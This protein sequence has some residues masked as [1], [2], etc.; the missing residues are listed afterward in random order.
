[1]ADVRETPLPDGSL[2]AELLARARALVP[3]LAERA[4]AATAARNVPDETIAEYR[5]AG[6]LRALQPRRFGGY[7]QS[8]GV[9]LRIVE[10]LTEGCASSA[11]VYAVLGE[12]QWVIALLPERGQEDIWAMTR[13]RWRREASCR[14]P[15]LAGV[16]KGGA[17][18]AATRSPAGACMHNGRSSA[19][20][21]KM[22]PATNIRAIWRCQWARS[23]SSTTGIRLGCAA[24]A[25]EALCCATCSSRASECFA[26]RPVGRHSAGAAG[27]YGLPAAARAPLLPGAVRF[28][29]GGFRAGAQGTGPAAVVVARARNGAVRPDAH[30]TRRGRGAYRNGQPDFRDSPGRERRVSGCRAS[31][32][33]SQRFTQ[34]PRRDA[35]FWVVEKGGRRVG[36]DQ[37]R[38]NGLRQRPAQF[39]DARHHGDRDAHHSERTGRD[40]AVQAVG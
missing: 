4:T 15:R 26:A 18:A 31:D 29:G 32:R 7:Q 19:P 34:S 11:W 2:G 13:R 22:R 35:G 21:A 36:G 3:N 10:A 14:A 5:R 17:S 27:A 8:V 6:I 25:A 39:G 28:A 40:G 23:T 9:F 12:M 24:R 37:W 16:R 30:A 38:P 20:A 33:D 1:M